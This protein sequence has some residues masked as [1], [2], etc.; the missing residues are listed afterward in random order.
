MF[1][2]AAII[3]SPNWRDYAKKYLSDCA[4]SIRAQDYNG[5]MKVFITDNET[6]EESYKFLREKL[7]DAVIHRNKNNDGF[8]KGNNDCMRL[9]LRARYDYIFLVS[10]YP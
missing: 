8:A 4:E 5:E 1:K 6:S 9:A 2:K 7:P 3:I 10:I